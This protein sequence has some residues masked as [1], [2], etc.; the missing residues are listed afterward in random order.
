MNTFIN[1]KKDFKPNLNFWELNPHLKYV[2]PFSELYAEDISKDKEISSKHM[3]CVFYL[4]EPDEDI[5]LYYRL[6]LDQLKDV[7]KN[8][9]PDFD[10]ENE[11]IQRCIKEY[12][13][14]CLT[15]MERMLK[16]TKELFKRR[17][18]FLKEAEYDFSTMKVIDA[19][20]AATPKLEEDFDKVVQKY[21]EE[22]NKS[23]QLLGNRK[24]SARELKRIQV[25]LTH[26]TEFRTL[27]E[28]ND[29]D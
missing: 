29:S 22:Q 2:R 18:A 8:F 25:D 20:I 7:C 21:K 9:N 6:P 4:S 5:N 3:W 16:I 26:D 10:D 27:E 19:A 23:I 14:I 11:I 1:I 15:V 24:Q 12:P 28:S 13:E 17:S